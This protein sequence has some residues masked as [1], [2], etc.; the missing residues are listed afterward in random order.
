MTE[1]H[2]SSN[3]VDKI[4][5]ISTNETRDNET[6]I[7]VHRASD[8][9]RYAPNVFSIWA[10]KDKNFVG[11]NI[12]LHFIEQKEIN[13]KIRPD[14]SP[15]PKK[16]MLTSVDELAM[17]RVDINLLKDLYQQIGNTINVLDSLN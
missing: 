16:E 5:T 7:P 10:T 2:K 15:L 11:A 3:S 1:N 8:F 17:I 6:I 14:N 12:Y 4:V 9:K 13:H